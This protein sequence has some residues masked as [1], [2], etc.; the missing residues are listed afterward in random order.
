MIDP[1][2]LPR[3]ALPSRYEVRLEPDLDAATFTGSVVIELEV[4]EVDTTLDGLVLNAAELEIHSARIDGVEAG[5]DVDAVLERVS[6]STGEPLAVG[7]HRVELTFDGVINDRLRGF[8]RSTF[9]DGDGVE[10]VIATTQMQSTDCRRAFPCLDEP[11]FKAVFS[12]TLVV[13]DGLMAISNSPEVSRR[14]T[15]GGRSEIAFADTMV[16]S[17]YLVA[18]VVGPLEATDP[19]DVDGSR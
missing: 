4:A 6:V 18:F 2:R 5:F 11:E 1:H 8:Y 13:A 17:S 7:T 10:R 12:I 19:I 9:V 16:M 3:H 14:E 15:D